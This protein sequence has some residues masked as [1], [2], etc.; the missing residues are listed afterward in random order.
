MKKEQYDKHTYAYATQGHVCRSSYL[1][2]TENTYGN[3]VY[4]SKNSKCVFDCFDET[5]DCSYASYGEKN[6][7]TH[8]A[9]AFVD[10]DQCYE[11]MS[12]VGLYKS[13]FIEW[14]N[15]GPHNSLYCKLCVNN[16]RY[17]FA[18]VGLKHRQYCIF[19]KQYTK[20]EWHDLVPQIIAKMIDDSVR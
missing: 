16:C 14:I 15:N 7:T 4:N 1:M 9:Y 13:Q 20:E 17:C 12:G 6:T 5:E 2:A 11:I 10:I 19:N 18:C 8:D 3:F